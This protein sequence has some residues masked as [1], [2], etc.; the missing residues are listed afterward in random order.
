M[1]PYTYIVAAL[2]VDATVKSDL[3]IAILTRIVNV[4]SFMWISLFIQ[5][6]YY[7]LTLFPMLFKECSGCKKFSRWLVRLSVRANN[8]H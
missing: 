4:K 8:S 7:T 3:A 5:L 2:K 6:T 1:S